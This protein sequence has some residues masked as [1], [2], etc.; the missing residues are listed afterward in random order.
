MKS[1]YLQ[2]GDGFALYS[3][4]FGNIQSVRNLFRPGQFYIFIFRNS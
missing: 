2:C 4:F 3:L 1:L